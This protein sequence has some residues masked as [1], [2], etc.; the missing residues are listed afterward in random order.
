MSNCLYICLLLSSVFH[1]LN[2]PIL[3]LVS[4]LIPLN[5]FC[6][7][8]V[9][10]VS[11]SSQLFSNKGRN[12]CKCCYVFFGFLIWFFV[13][14]M[15]GVWDNTYSIITCFLWIRLLLVMFTCICCLKRFVEYMFR[16][17]LVLFVN[18]FI[19]ARKISTRWL[20]VLNT[21]KFGFFLS[22]QIASQHFICTWSTMRNYLK[23]TV[24]WNYRNVNFLIK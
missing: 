19:Y 22:I 15:S 13:I 6:L 7:M 12:C 4:I 24:T 2:A 16:I 10:I 5:L 17:L 18:L 9:Y 8:F 3:S 21:M 14:H 23:I 1:C 11:H 20:L